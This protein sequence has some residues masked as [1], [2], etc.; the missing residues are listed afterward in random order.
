MKI[1]PLKK[2]EL[3]EKDFWNDLPAYVKAGIE[4]GQKQAA[5]G[6]LTPN[7]EVMKKYAKYL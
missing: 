6:K 1:I 7:D 2:T 4:R 3:K 5:E